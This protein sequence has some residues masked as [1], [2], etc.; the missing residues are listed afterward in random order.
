MAKVLVLGA[1]GNLG[2]HVSRQAIAAG[3]AV[4]V[5]VHKPSKLPAEAREYPAGQQDVASPG[6]IDLA[7]RDARQKEAVDRP[8]DGR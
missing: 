8:T 4:S 3:H 7:S 5:L 1:T 6:R 2:R